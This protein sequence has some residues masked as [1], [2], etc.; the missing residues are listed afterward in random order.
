[1]MN[2]VLNETADIGR[3]W[4]EHQEILERLLAGDEAGAERAARDHAE[5]AGE[6]TAQSLEAIGN[7]P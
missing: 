2:A 1:S 3:I 7:T 4:Q 5:R 6:V